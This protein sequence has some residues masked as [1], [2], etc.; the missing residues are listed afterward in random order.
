MQNSIKSSRHFLFECERHRAHRSVKYLNPY[1]YDE[2]WINHS[3]DRIPRRFRNAGPLKQRPTPQAGNR[4]R[5]KTLNEKTM[6][7]IPQQHGF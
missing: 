5:S 7:S 1:N 3:T 4:K 6:K 2:D